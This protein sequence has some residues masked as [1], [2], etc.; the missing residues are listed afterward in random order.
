M[1]LPGSFYLEAVLEAAGGVPCVLTDVEFTN[2]C[3]IPKK[4]SDKPPSVLSTALEAESVR[5]RDLQ[6]HTG[7]IDVE[8]RHS[9]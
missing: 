9:I 8:I 2:T 1:Q 6:A 4:G 3:P 7:L 5:P